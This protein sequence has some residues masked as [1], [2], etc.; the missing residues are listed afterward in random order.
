M[1][2]DTIP[3]ESVNDLLARDIAAAQAQQVALRRA[4]SEPLP[5]PLSL[6]FTAVELQQFG[7]TIRPVVASDFILLKKLNSPLYRRTFALAEHARKIQTAEIPEG[8]PLP[9]AENYDEEECVEMVYQFLIP[10]PQARAELKR[11]REFFRE[12]AHVYVT[13]RAPVN[14]LPK[15]VAT[16][17]ENFTNAF[18]TAIRYEGAKDESEQT[19]FTT[20]PGADATASAG[21]SITSPASPAAIPPRKPSSPT[22]SL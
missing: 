21:G 13:D 10:L 3:A 5:G 1:N 7:F 4:N 12:Q 16:V 8:S 6:A 19:V 20:P 11:G 18:A 2:T 17:I 9:A 22:N 15:L 14:A